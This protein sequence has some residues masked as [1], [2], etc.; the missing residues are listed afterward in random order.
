MVLLTMSLF[1]RAQQANPQGPGTGANAGT[2]LRNGTG[3]SIDTV[4]DPSIF[5]LNEWKVYAWNSTNSDSWV[6]NYAGYYTDTA[7]SMNTLN[8]W[9]DGASP[10]YAPN[11]LGDFVSEDDHSFSG[12][13]QGF[14]FG[15]YSINIPG[16]DDYAYLLINGVEVWNHEGCCDDHFDV[17]QGVLTDTTT[18]EYRV[19]EFGGGSYGLIDLVELSLV[20][21]ATSTFIPC[22]N[23]TST[24]TISASGGF[25]PYSGTGT[26]LSLIHISEPTRP[27]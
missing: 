15:F 7:L 16:H 25:P 8:Y 17:W 5:G 1:S 4:G 22:Y 2:S 21:S 11:Y 12:K 27:Y 10:S 24:V 26:F 23:G 20:A 6:L 14:P 13:R 19:M 18:I 3:N 9:N